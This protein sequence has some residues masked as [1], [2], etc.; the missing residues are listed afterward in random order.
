[1][2]KSTLFKDYASIC[3]KNNSEFFRATLFK[4]TLY[5]L[6]AGCKI[7]NMELA[8]AHLEQNEIIL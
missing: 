5:I 1:M 4:N 7:L 6:P 2:I 3:S 8:K